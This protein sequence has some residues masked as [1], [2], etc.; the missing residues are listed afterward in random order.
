MLRLH[1]DEIIV[2][3]FAGGGGASE[4]TRL[5]TGRDPDYAINHDREALAMHIANH[6]R[7]KHYCEDVFDVDP[8]KIC[9]GRRIGYAW[10]SPDCT[11]FS[12][13]RGAKPFR[14]RNRARRRRG[15]AWVV[16]KWA[17]LVKPR[18][19]FVEN[20]EELEDW[21]PLG[22]DGRPDPERKGFTFRRWRA[23][24]ENAGYVVESRQLRACDY[25][26]PTTRRR[27]FIIA[28]S[29]GQPIVWPSP[30]HGPGTGRPYRTAAECIQWELPCPSIFERKKPLAEKTLRRVGRG[31]WRY[32]I[33]ASSPFVVPVTHAGDDRIHGL[34]APLPTITAAHRGELAYVAPT[35]V[36]TGYGERVGQDP[37]ALDL[38][39]PLGTIVAGGSKHAL[40]AAFLAKHYGGHEATGQTVLKPIATITTQDHHSLVLSHMVKLMGTCPDGQPL[41]MPAPTIRAQGTHLGEVRAFLT[42]YYGTGST[43]QA[44]QLPLGTVTTRDRFGLVTVAGEDYE[45][46]DIGMRMLAP[47]ELFRAQGFS[48]SYII[49]PLLEDDPI[50]AMKA[51]RAKRVTRKRSPKARL[52]KR[53]TKGAQIRMCGNSVPPLVVEAIVR[54]NFGLAEQ[55]AA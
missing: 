54:A 15:L 44:L 16:V 28:R 20:V 38:H 43:G 30:S 51:D 5:A 29:D 32:V 7:T 18:V 48:D 35:L 2:D 13:A 26:A 27:L 3:L 46:A 9:A 22:D 23:Q 36:Q 47:R 24:L 1:E 11:Y 53:L 19:I 14:D 8:R 17:K 10:F 25:G 6:P 39:K 49:D 21:G 40:V 42:K 37:R 4:G 52:A 41:A 34:D 50:A 31:I 33:G 55:V 12:K 45:I